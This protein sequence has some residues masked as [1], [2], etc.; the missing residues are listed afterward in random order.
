VLAPGSGFGDT[1][2]GNLRLSFA[3]SLDELEEG[4]DRIAA[5]VAARSP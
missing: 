4:L 3:A 1:G 2:E 5:G